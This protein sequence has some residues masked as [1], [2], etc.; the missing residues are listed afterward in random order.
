MESTIGLIKFLQSNPDARKIFGERELKI[1][2]KQAWA[3]E[4]TQSEKNRLSRDIRKKL[5]FIEKIARF[6]EAFKLK[7]GASVKEKVDEAVITIQTDAFATKIKRIWLFGSTIQKTRTLG[8]SDVDI[9]VEFDDITP[10]EALKFRRRILGN[11]N[12]KV[13]VQVLNV[14]PKEVQAE[15]HEHGSVLHERTD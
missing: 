10:T 5:E 15:V 2:E 8:H 11:F 13:D 12:E 14:L 1:I 3:V 6:S 4:L 7:K 9:A